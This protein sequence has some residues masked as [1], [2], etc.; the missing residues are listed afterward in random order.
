[1]RFEHDGIVIWYGTS[2]APAPEGTVP[3]G[4]AIAITV[5]IQPADASNQ[6][7]IQ[8]RI[9]QDSVKKLTASYLRNA[10]IRNAQYF[11]AHFP[12]SR[13]GDIVEY[14]V[15][16]RCAGRQVP[17]LN[18]NQSFPS[19]F[20]VV[21][22]E[23]ES[24]TNGSRT[25]SQDISSSSV[26]KAI[27]ASAPQITAKPVTPTAKRPK[28]SATKTLAADE[29]ETL[30][31]PEPPN[32]VTHQITGQLIDEDS[33]IPLSRYTVHAYDLNAAQESESLG[34]DFSDRNGYFQLA[35]SEPPRRS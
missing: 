28:M 18:A 24:S 14:R 4:E 6:V 2:D 33:G 20:R 12:E 16:C 26:K 30:P 1:M 35:Y 17:A 13:F 21:I 8:Y 11:R 25:R 15:V 32:L 29:P 23:N 3:T 9:N 31:E 19:S 27:A 10:S 5:G 22:T 34:V 7:E